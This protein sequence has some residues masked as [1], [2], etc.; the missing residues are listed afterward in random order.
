MIKVLF[1][2]G[3]I[4]FVCSVGISYAAI[5]SEAAVL[6]EKSKQTN[7]ISESLTD[8]IPQLKSASGSKLKP[9]NVQPG[10]V[11]SIPAPAD[12]FESLITPFLKT[13]AP[14]FYDQ[15]IKREPKSS[16]VP[17]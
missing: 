3:F 6:N 5:G 14:I 13:V 10:A 15:I 8:K 17:S 12:T 16:G 11:K 7:K 2:C 9:V 1:T 4:L